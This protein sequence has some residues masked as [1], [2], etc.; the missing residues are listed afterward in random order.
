[1]RLDR[2]DRRMS[3][4]FLCVT[5]FLVTIAVPVRTLR[6][7]GVYHV[8]RGVLF[9]STSIAASTL[10]ARADGAEVQGRRQLGLTGLL[11]VAPFAIVA[12][13]WVG[14][15]P[16]WVATPAEN[17]MH[18]LVLM[19][20]A[21]AVVGG[22]VL[23]KDVLSEAGERFY[24]TLGFAGIILAGPLYLVWNSFRSECIFAKEHAGQVPPVLVSLNAVLDLL[25][26]LGGALTYLATATYAASLG[27]TQ[28]RQRHRRPGP[29][30]RRI[31]GITRAT[32]WI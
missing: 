16:P 7:A 24:S 29:S 11:L 1:M 27:R 5:P 9:A 21:I 6:I 25:L 23:L 3:Y 13:L 32:R 15:G 30:P 26:F 12:L 8:I 19:V 2:L 20:I 31:H 17:Q 18:Y 14:L 28:R 22:V 4:A 10:G